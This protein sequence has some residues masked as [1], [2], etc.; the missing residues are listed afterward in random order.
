MARQPIQNLQ[1][2]G[3]TSTPSA[4]PV[5]AYS[6]AP[7]IPQV[8]KGAQ[9]A[10]ALGT[11]SG[12][13]NR[14]ARESAANKQNEL[15]KRMA[16]YG[17]EILAQ[18]KEF[19]GQEELAAEFPS[20][21]AQ[22]KMEMAQSIATNRY[23]DKTEARLTEWLANDANLLSDGGYDLFKQE[24]LNEFGE[25]TEGLDFV[26]AGMQ[27]GVNQVFSNKIT[28]YVAAADA[29]T[30]EVWEEDT[31]AN[32]RYILKNSTSSE[33][34]AVLIQKLDET[35][36]NPYKDEPEY[37]RQLIVGTLIEHDMVSDSPP[38]TEDIMNSINSKGAKWLSSKR[39]LAQYED[40]KGDIVAAR[41]QNLRNKASIKQ[42]EQQ[43][44]L[45]DAQ[46]RLNTYAE[47]N[48]IAA[49][50]QVL[51][52]SAGVTGEG[53]A[54]ANAIYKMAEVALASA[55]VDVEESQAFAASYESDLVVRAVKGELTRKVALAEIASSTQ[56]RPSD[57]QAIRN[58]LDGIMA[59]SNLIAAAKHTTEYNNRVGNAAQRLDDNY[60]EKIQGYVPIEPQIRDVW[61]DTVFDLIQNFVNKE[62]AIPEGGSLR[63]IYNQAEE[64]TDKRVEK[65]R[66]ANSLIP[67]ETP[68]E[69]TEQEQTEEP[70]EIPTVTTQEE[71]DALPAGAQ[72]LENGKL[73]T[74][75]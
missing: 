24:L 62:N 27:Q 39:T 31:V 45:D 23:R 47:A 32:I 10:E 18:N 49:I 21:S 72:F 52:K 46:S 8:S 57:K 65:I 25:E 36:I 1:G 73:F 6:G 14:A 70:Q 22:L 44:T 56:I 69:N 42:L 16:A 51:A 43:Q 19:G 58:K 3:Q 48:D 30:K 17:Q 61:D 15:K 60:L 40:S 37:L 38:M 11:M 5:D 54:T 41:F 20:A 4:T 66:A 74:K 13:V 50:R 67:G 34:A 29:K 59:G 26:T 75:P 33:Q 2:Y 35:K 28:A 55:E 12:N 64:I 7:A 63:E 53:A 71:Y 68:Q 9:L